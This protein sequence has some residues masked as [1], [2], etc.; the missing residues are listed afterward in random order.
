MFWRKAFGAQYAHAGIFLKHCRAPYVFHVQPSSAKFFVS[1]EAEICCDELE[2]V[3]KPHDQIFVI[4]WCK[5]KEDQDTVLRR[6]RDCTFPKSLKFKYNGYYGSCQTFC[7]R[8][9]N[10]Q[11]LLDLNLE[12][13]FASASSMKSFFGSFLN[14]RDRGL[15]LL[16][17]MNERLGYES[18]TLHGDPEDSSLYDESRDF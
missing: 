14:D 3:V 10:Q 13:N 8:I 7:A 12:A 2:S 15:D 5:T 17:K 9:F 4:R 1:K 16:H 6:A 11:T 18:S